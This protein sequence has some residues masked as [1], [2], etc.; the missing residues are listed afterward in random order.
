MEVILDGKKQTCKEFE[1]VGYN[2]TF[3]DNGKII[4]LAKG[5]WV[6]KAKI[7]FAKKQGKR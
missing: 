2:P 1:L 3:F 4:I 5:K 6:K 7:D